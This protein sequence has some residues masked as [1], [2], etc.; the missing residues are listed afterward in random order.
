M[1][2]ASLNTAVVDRGE[3]K[4]EQFNEN[5]KLEVDY[6]FAGKKVSNTTLSITLSLIQ[7]HTTIFKPRLLT[8]YSIP[9]ILMETGE[10]VTGK[11]V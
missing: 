9:S 10:F 5:R 7:S 8:A 11:A 2:S 3:A 4:V 6:V 1:L